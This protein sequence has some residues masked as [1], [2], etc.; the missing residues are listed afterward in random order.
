[1]RI[2]SRKAFRMFSERHPESGPA[3]DDFYGKIK[4]CSP[5]NMAEFRQT[6]P[7]ADSVGDC[8]VFNVGGNKYRVIVHLDYEVQTMWI[9]FVLA[10]AEYDRERWKDDC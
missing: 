7:S 6:F 5:S 2:I 3:L 8:I 9:R 1:M 10:H 4:R